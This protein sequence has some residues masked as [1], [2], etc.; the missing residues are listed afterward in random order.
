M[1]R[2]GYNGGNWLGKGITSSTAADALASGNYALAVADNNALTNKFGD[3]T[4]GG[5][6]FDG[7][8]VDDTTVLVK[9]TH[10]V[11]LDVDGLVTPND[12]IIFATNY[13]FNGN[14]NWITGDVDYDGVHTQNDAII[15]ATFYNGTLPSLPEPGGLAGLALASTHV[16]RGRARGGAAKR[17]GA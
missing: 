6:Q 17:A 12:A 16:L 10:R 5:P 13:L 3:G 11:D 8:S 9:F 15:F 7:Q 2:S 4:I 1:V 14:A